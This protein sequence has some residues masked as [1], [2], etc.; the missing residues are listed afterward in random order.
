[1]DPDDARGRVE[2]SLRIVELDHTLDKFPSQ[3]SGG[4]RRRVGIARANVSEPPLV[5][6]DSPTAGLDPIT[7]NSIITF[8]IKERDLENTTNVIVTHRY[9]DGHLLAN[10]RYNPQ[11]SG[12]EPVSRDGGR[13]A[14]RTTFMVLNEGRLAFQGS[15]RELASSTDSYVRN[16]Y[17][18]LKE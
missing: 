1:V 18:T 11:S 5:L 2:E 9:Q 3:L 13:P 14:L 10:F 12:L 16:F 6:Y 7:A 4:M 15:Q 8:I 17:R